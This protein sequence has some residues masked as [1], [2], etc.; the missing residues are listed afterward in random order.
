MNKPVSVRDTFIILRRRW[1]R[2]ARLFTDR[3]VRTGLPSVCEATG[4]TTLRSAGLSA[5]DQRLV[6]GR[7]SSDM[8]S[9]ATV[10]MAR[11]VGPTANGKR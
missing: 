6:P 7:V 11:D 10:A 9:G 1:K 2:D 3:D 5:H 4:F 8:P